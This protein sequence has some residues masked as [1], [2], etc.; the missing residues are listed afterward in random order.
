MFDSIISPS[1]TYFQIDVGPLCP[2]L[3][4]TSNRKMVAD[5][6]VYRV[7]ANHQQNNHRARHSLRPKV[8][9]MVLVMRRSYFRTLEGHLAVALTAVV[10]GYSK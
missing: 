10:L 8:L 7:V 5:L 1:G 9:V 2:S 4:K 3:S 6:M